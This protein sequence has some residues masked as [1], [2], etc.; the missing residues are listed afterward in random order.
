MKKVLVL[1]FAALIL[2]PFAAGSVL[3]SHKGGK[4]HRLVIQVSENNVKKMNIAINNATNVTKYYGVGNVEIE[5]VAYGPGLD[6]FHKNSKVAKRLQSLHAFGNIKFGVCGNTM[7]KRKITKNDLLQDAFI[8]N[9]II[10]S[11]V[12]RLIELQEQGYSY[13]KL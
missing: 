5:I 4:I 8:Q 1:I 11:G 2:L 9:S 6:M 3:A 10:P 7:R 13:V 12:V